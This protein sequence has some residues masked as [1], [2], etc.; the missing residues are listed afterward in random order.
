MT[1]KTF[2]AETMLL[3]LKQVQKELGSDAV[4]VSV[5]QA[6]S[7]PAWQVWQ[8]PVFEIVASNDR[9]EKHESSRAQEKSN[10]SVVPSLAHQDRVLKKDVSRV[11]A[12]ETQ[13]DGTGNKA[14]PWEIDQKDQKIV[15]GGILRKYYSHLEKQGVDDQVLKKVFQT[16]MDMLGPGGLSDESRV[17]NH[18]KK[19]LESKIKAVRLPSSAL[20]FKIAVVVGQSGSGKTSAGLKLAAH[21]IH[22]FGKNVTWICS[23]TVRTGAIAEAKTITST[24]GITL[25]LAYSPIEITNILAGLKEDEVVIVDT[26]GCNPYDELAVVELG[27]ILAR[28][29]G[30]TTYLTI[31]ASMKEEDALQMAAAIG[32]L[33]PNGL[34]FTRMDE[35]RYFGGLFNLTWRSQIP[36]AYFTK[37]FDIFDDFIPA[38]PMKLID[39]LFDNKF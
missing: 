5:R 8:K 9:P 26:P 20:P 23:D 22:Q 25:H 39:A 34:L 35:T 29:P 10:L 27:S 4:V 11:P 6:L 3:A 38:T 13:Q 37:G 31:P 7:G 1:T 17:K 14:H 32:P 33:A 2:R 18:I 36:L 24:L 21:A 16:C 15:F 19:Q 30:R 28:I 12:K